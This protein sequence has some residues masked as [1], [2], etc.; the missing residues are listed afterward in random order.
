MEELEKNN[1]SASDEKE[2][3]TGAEKSESEKNKLPIDENQ[4]EMTEGCEKEQFI[5]SVP[6]SEFENSFVN[7]ELIVNK[8]EKKTKKQMNYILIS[9]ISAMIGGIITGILII[10]IGQAFN[11]PIQNGNGTSK[12]IEIEKSKTPFVE[13]AKKVGPSVVSIKVTAIQQSFFG[14]TQVQPEGSG[15]IVRG[16]GYIVTNYH[17]IMDAIDSDGKLSSNSKIE[18]YLAND[19]KNSYKAKLVGGDIRTDLAVLKINKTGLT[20]ADLGDS[21]K[22]E[23][24]EIVVAIGSPGGIDLMGSVTQGIISGVNRKVMTEGGSEINLIQTDAAINPGNSGG[25]LANSKGQVVGINELKVVATGYEGI[26]FAIPINSA[27]IIINNLISDGYIKRPTIGIYA[28]AEYDET[29]AKENN[30]PY[31]VLVDSVKPLG[32]AFYAGIKK[33]DIITK[34]NGIKIKNFNDLNI[35]KDKCKINQIVP[36]EIYR[37]EKTITLNVKLLEN[38]K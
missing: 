10:I 26:G 23:A 3:S 25:A 38:K 19:N 16:D 5:E 1:S 37:N 2:L 18:I 11:L 28:N 6:G 24:G 17:V 21:S 34:F 35:E 4:S 30:L 20:E 15:I 13:I 12:K 36:V 27:K 22:L 9:L 8:K 7:D 33:G 14:N 29:Y 31:G 32:G